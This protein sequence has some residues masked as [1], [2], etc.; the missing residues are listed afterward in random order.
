MKL[1]MMK[2]GMVE[3]FYVQK[4][5]ADRCLAECKRSDSGARLEEITWQKN[6]LV[7]YDAFVEALDDFLDQLDW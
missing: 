7:G 1:L 5:V 6:P 2:A 4:D 3:I